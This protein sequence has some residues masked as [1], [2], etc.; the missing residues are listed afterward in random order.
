MRFI[1]LI[2]DVTSQRVLI[3]VQKI[4][5]IYTDT[6]LNKTI[7]KVSEKEFCVKESEHEILLKIRG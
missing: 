5:L 7:I 3:N 1:E 6:E 2:E 4:D